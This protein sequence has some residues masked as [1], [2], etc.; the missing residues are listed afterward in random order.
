MKR[1]QFE[2]YL[3]SGTANNITVGVLAA[4]G[5]ICGIVL[6]P[7]SSPSRLTV[8]GTALPTSVT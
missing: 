7:K 5:L 8:K 2:E 4:I 6:S 1:K 3:R